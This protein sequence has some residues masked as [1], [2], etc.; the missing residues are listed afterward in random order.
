MDT[1]NTK[2]IKP[3]EKLLSE[4]E[5][6]TDIPQWQSPSFTDYPISQGSSKKLSAL[7]IGWVIVIGV[8]VAASIGAGSGSCQFHEEDVTDLGENA[9]K[10][11]S[12]Y[13]EDASSESE[14]I[15]QHPQ[16]QLLS[17]IGNSMP[18]NFQNTQA[19]EIE[20]AQFLQQAAFILA[21]GQRPLRVLHIGDSHV[22]ARTFPLSVKK[23]LIRCLGEAENA[24]EGRGVWFSYIGRNGAT[25][26]TFLSNSYMEK[27][28]TQRPDL[29]ILSIGTNEA[30]TMNYQEQVHE[31]QLNT[32][33]SHLQAVCP[34]AVILITTPPGDYLTVSTVNYYS[35]KSRSQ[36]R[37]RRHY[38]KRPN[39][40]SQ[41]CAAFL[42]DYG[43]GN[44][45]A[46]WDLY[47]ICGGKEAVLSN[48][49][50]NKMMRS[51]YIHFEPAGY[52]LQG[53]L[54][55]EALVKALVQ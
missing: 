9:F 14:G 38:T 52:E 45:L 3:T 15:M 24:D 51:D 53:R 54:L 12:A 2:N 36:R 20:Q 40:M 31:E 47:T 7:I 6:H 27:I 11:T 1:N 21:E 10:P 46:I 26:S 18:S 50:A 16:I 42:V 19:N 22:A 44:H 23:T 41:R 39:P 13:S 48:W 28:A 37:K 33:F 5:S 55:G 17:E 30:H 43:H 29:I 49:I 4:Y 35:T 32:F 8:A 34:N 25:S